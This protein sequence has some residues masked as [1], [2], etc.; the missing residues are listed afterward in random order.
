MITCDPKG[1]V[2]LGPIDF[3][4]QAIIVLSLLA[5]ALETLPRLTSEQ[6]QQ[7]RLFEIASF[8]S[9]W[10]SIS[11]GRSSRAGRGPIC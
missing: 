4:I 8:S 7:L 1:R 10:S 2:Q 3:V 6:R 5:F 11:S 9:S